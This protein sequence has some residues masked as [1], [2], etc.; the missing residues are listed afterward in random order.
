MQLEDGG[1]RRPSGTS[2]NALKVSTELMPGC[3]KSRGCSLLPFMVAFR[4]YLLLLS[5]LPRG[6]GYWHL[7]DPFGTPGHS[8]HCSG[9]RTEPAQALHAHTVGAAS[10]LAVNWQC[11][12]GPHAPVYEED[13]TWA[14]AMP[15]RPQE[16]QDSTLLGPSPKPHTRKESTP[17]AP[18]DLRWKGGDF[19]RMG[20][21]VMKPAGLISADHPAL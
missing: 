8:Q 18:G 17:S 21:G 9:K 10:G 5:V 7:G 15:R 20:V 13:S 12:A 4:S 11:G 1:R 3:P 19:T 6:S 14:R 2:H 16:A